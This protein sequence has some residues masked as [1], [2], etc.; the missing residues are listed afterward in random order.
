MYR[1]GGEALFPG[2]MFNG[3]PIAFAAQRFPEQEAGGLRRT[4]ESDWL[5]PP[6]RQRQ[7]EHPQKEEA[8]SIHS[9]LIVL[10]KGVVS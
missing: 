1:I 10:V 7:Q 9:M 5:Q 3:A 2:A 4:V 6:K 8:F